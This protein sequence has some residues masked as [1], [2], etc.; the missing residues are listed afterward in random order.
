ML[1]KPEAQDDQLVGDP[2]AQSGPSAKVAAASWY[3]LAVLTC[4]NIF[5]YVDRVAL[6]ILMQSIKT[7]LHL[8]DA[9]LGL[10]SGVA[11]ALFYAVL[12]VP[13]ALLADRTSRVRVIAACLAMAVWKTGK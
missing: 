13:L 6:S 5:G 4:I 12:G 7:E 1:K 2:A 3:A 10:L 8:S 9:Q 11:F